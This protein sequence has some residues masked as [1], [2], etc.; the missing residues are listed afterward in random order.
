MW[1]RVVSIKT[2]TN[3]LFD[4][5]NSITKRKTNLPYCQSYT[6]KLVFRVKIVKKNFLYYEKY[7]NMSRRK[8]EGTSLL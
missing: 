5:F 1:D 6:N 3:E 4:K 7:M 8:T 2:F